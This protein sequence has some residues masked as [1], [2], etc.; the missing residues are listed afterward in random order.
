MNITQVSEMGERPLVSLLSGMFNTGY[1]ADLVIGPGSDDCAVLD[2]GGGEYLVVTTDMLHRKTDFPQQ[3]TPWQIGWM[4]AAVN[5]SDVASMGARPTGILFAI[6]MSS[7]TP[8]SF[9]E[10]MA[11]GMSDCAKACDTTV[12]G[13]DIDTHD[14]LTITGTALGM[15]EKSCLLKRKGAMAG[16][17]VCVTG[18][19]GS[20][21]AALHAIEQ[22]IHI[23][24]PFLNTLLEPY[25]RVAEGQAL[26]RSGAVN[27]MMDTSDGL[28]MSLHDLADINGVGFQIYE[29]MLPVHEDMGNYVTCDPD[30]QMDF[31][32]YTGGDFE[33]LFT[34]PPDKLG[35]ARSACN[36]SIIGEVV[37]QKAGIRIE[38][39]EG[40]NRSINRKGYQQLDN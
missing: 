7:D 13:G 24:D 19:A 35:E 38:R 3:M 8:V 32:L 29:S 39:K 22:G 40:T 17:K 21:G 23:P 16:D 12:I 25:P 18:F 37:E 30:E 5:L 4:S 10:E 33:L 26:A 34:V 9:V 14:E 36:L 6:G 27:C 20:A 2:V 1:N 15:V 11:R 31:A 28:A